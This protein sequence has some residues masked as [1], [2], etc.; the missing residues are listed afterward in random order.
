MPIDTSSKRGSLSLIQLH[1][2]P[3]E[4]I[5]RQKQI[6]CGSRALQKQP[7]FLSCWF[8]SSGES[9][10]SCPLFSMPGLQQC[11]LGAVC[12][13]KVRQQNIPG[14]PSATTREGSRAQ[15]LEKRGHSRLFREASED[16]VWLSLSHQQSDPSALHSPC[17]SGAPK[18]G[19][20]E[21]TCHA[22]GIASVRALHQTCS[23][24]WPGQSTLHCG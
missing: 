22:G 11:Y 5:C 23:L 21:S 16:G 17:C 8:P 9:L 20:Q 4:I 12:F 3:L 2:Q 24:L 13:E 10:D 6:K 19:P 18:G 14:N 7:P 15:R 1:P